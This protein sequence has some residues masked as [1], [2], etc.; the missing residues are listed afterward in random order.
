T[1][2]ASASDRLRDVVGFE[3]D[4][5][6]PFTADAVAYDARVRGRRESDGQLDVELVVVPLQM[7]KDQQAA[8]GSLS[9]ELAGIDVGGPDGAPLGV[10]LLPPPQRRQQRDPAVIWNI[11]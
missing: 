4:R 1:L 2:P 10:N 8:L 7:L 5:Q 9:A 6:T 11:G 3:I